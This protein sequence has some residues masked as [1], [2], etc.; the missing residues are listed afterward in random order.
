MFAYNTS[1][2]STIM[3]TPFELLYGM[4][5]RLPSFPNQD[6]QRLHYG[7]SFASQRLQIL[8]KARLVASQ[9]AQKQ[10]ESYKTQF[11]K[12]T[13]DHS[14]KIGD[15]VLYHEQTFLGKNKKLA[16][17]WLGPATIV[18]VSETNVH[19]KCQSGKIKLLNVSHIK[20]FFIPKAEHDSAEQDEFEFLDTE[21]KPT[22]PNEV[23]SEPQAQRAQTR[24][25]TRLLHER[26]TINF[27]EAD[28]RA[29]LSRISVQLYKDKINFTSL[30]QAD[31][32][33]WK[34]FSVE[35]IHFFLS[36]QREHTPDYAQYIQ[37][38]K[39]PNP[40]QPIVSLPNSPGGSTDNTPFHSANNSPST[41]P[42]SSPSPAVKT[43]WPTF[44]ASID[45]RNILKKSPLARLTRAASKKWYKFNK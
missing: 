13:S 20:K 18:K 9:N 17:K 14:Y 39:V 24:A 41:S 36:G 27:V 6:I 32:L 3:S 35:D 44:H 10:G 15:L 26:H 28:L 12:Q 2:H 29:Q 30:P 33:L 1:Y 34:S 25:L 16:P 37:I 4:K 23:L 31:Q 19:I 40:Q 42:P 21:Q 45:P 38:H 5:P 8:Q 11:D 22:Q 7:E 43:P